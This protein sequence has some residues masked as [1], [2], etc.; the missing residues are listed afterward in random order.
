M[1]VSHAPWLCARRVSKC[2]EHRAVGGDSRAPHSRAPT[3]N[4]G[5][6]A[7]GDRPPEGWEKTTCLWPGNQHQKH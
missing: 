6:T 3:G 5:V 7:V 1:H 2:T 4:A